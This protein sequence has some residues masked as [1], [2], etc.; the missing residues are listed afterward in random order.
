MTKQPQE[1]SPRDYIEDRHT[2][3]AQRI[4]AKAVNLGL[5]GTQAHRDRGTLLD[6]TQPQT[7]SG[8][9][10]NPYTAAAEKFLRE[11]A[12]A[13]GIDEEIFHDAGS[14]RE[15]LLDRGR[16]LGGVEGKF[17][18]HTAAVGDFLNE[19]ALTMGAIDQDTKSIDVETLKTKLLDAARQDREATA[20]RVGKEG[21]QA[22]AFHNYLSELALTLGAVGA[23]NAELDTDA[24]KQKLLE[25]GR[26]VNEKLAAGKKEG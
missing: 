5:E 9:G 11:L 23:D 26:A 14:L 15:A 4:A 7:A 21:E 8:D 12:G 16:E 18:A 22:N 24:L 1:K 2:E 19:L 10:Q 20:E 6:M 13:M 17:E 25:Y 3:L